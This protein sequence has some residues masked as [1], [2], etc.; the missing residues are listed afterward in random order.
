[1]HRNMVSVQQ[2]SKYPPPGWAVG[3]LAKVVAH[4]VCKYGALLWCRNLSPSHGVFGRMK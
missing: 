3:G 1:V 4:L 2:G